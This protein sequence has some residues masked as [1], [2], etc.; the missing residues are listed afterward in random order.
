MQSML[1][2]CP[3]GLARRFTGLGIAPS[4]GGAGAEKTRDRVP[5]ASSGSLPHSRKGSVTI[6]M[7]ESG[8]TAKQ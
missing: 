5:P 4:V 2:P 8:G 3:V 7:S 6:R 1:L